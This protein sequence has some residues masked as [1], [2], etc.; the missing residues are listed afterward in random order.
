MSDKYTA[1][2][3]FHFD[4]K[5]K[6][7]ALKKLTPPIHI[8][9]KP[10]NRCNHRCHYCCYRNNA[11]FLGELMNETDEIP[12]DKMKQIIADIVG[13]GV[14]AVTFSGGGE[15]LLY[16]GFSQAVEEL[17]NGNVKTAVLTNGSLLKGRA[18]KVLGDNAT[19]V[20]VSMDAANKDDY[21]AARSI[22]KDAFGEVC[23]NIEQFAKIKRAG[24]ELGINFIVTQKNHKE[25]F[26]F[27]KMMKELGADHVKISEAVVSVE[28]DKNL[29][30]V[31]HFRESVKEQIA[32]GRDLLTEDRFVIIDKILHR[33]GSSEGGNNYEKGYSQCLFAQCLTVIGA[34]LNVYTCQDKA[35]TKSGL[36][37]SIQDCSFSEFWSASLTKEKL[38]N[39]NPKLICN[40]HCVAHEKNLA[41]LDYLGTDPDHLEFV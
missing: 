5:L 4:S 30:Y 9:L 24:C 27:L 39:L 21:A 19:W 37:G 33:P 1:S 20:R 2:K 3:I 17:A 11:L 8:R 32:K 34:D 36:L 41:L 31:A 16:S 18:A 22:K 13:M 12:A 7:L 28:Q 25:V 29:E 38:V 14:K 10:T 40:H 15:P 6:E 26:E 23:E 35:Y